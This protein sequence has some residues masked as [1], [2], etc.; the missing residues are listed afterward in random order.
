MRIAEAI[1]HWKRAGEMAVAR[2]ANIEAI[3]HPRKRIAS[4]AAAARDT[5]SCWP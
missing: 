1:D 3:D 2:S 5:G 4:A